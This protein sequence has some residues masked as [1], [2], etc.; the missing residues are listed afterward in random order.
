M[1]GD[2]KED[3]DTCINSGIDSVLMVRGHGHVTLKI[4]EPRPKF[5]ITDPREL[6]PIVEGKRDPELSKEFEFNPPLWSKE[7]WT[8]SK[9]RL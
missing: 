1:V 2:Y 8:G 5:I 3:I 6:I 4:K 7:G 9:E